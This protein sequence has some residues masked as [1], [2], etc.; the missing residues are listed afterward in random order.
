ML[1]IRNLEDSRLM[2]LNHHFAWQKEGSIHSIDPLGKPPTH[3]YSLIQCDCTLLPSLCP[4]RALLTCLLDS[5]P[6]LNVCELFL[7][8][9][10]RSCCSAINTTPSERDL[11]GNDTLFLRADCISGLQLLAIFSG[12][13][14]K[15]IFPLS[16]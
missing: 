3:K 10:G 2:A 5:L 16:F 12:G 11:P 8:G 14:H 6:H 9:P 4:P 7:S 15:D 1:V 13:L